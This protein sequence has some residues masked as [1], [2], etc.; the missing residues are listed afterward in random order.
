VR[1]LMI[2]MDVI[3][4]AAVGSLAGTA[5]IGRPTVAQLLVTAIVEGAATA[6]FAPA[7][8]ILLREIVPRER[9]VGGLSWLQAT[10]GI[11]SMAGP[12]LGGT[13][14]FLHPVAPF[15]ADAVSYGLSAILMSTIT[16]PPL[17]R[18]HPDRADARVTAG[19]RWLCHQPRIIRVVLY[20]SVL[21]LAGSGAEILVLLGLRQ[22]G[23]SSIIV[24][25]VLACA[26]VGAIVGAMLAGRMLRWLRGNSLYLVVGLSWAAGSVSF[27]IV[28]PVWFVAPMLVVLMLFAPAAGIRLGD[29][30]VNQA[31]RHLLGRVSTAQGMLA[32]GL[33]S[34]GPALV[35]VLLDVLGVAGSW[36]ILA[37]ICLGGTAIAV[38]SAAPTEGARGAPAASGAQEAA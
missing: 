32:S 1:A 15:A 28:R 35:G 17:V 20:A 23:T 2:G 27:A 37:V 33:A 4:L 10:T 29:L 16:V 6:A 14:F 5:G 36:V 34:V 12:L 19:L 26:G 22:E 25:M 21:N 13:L 11:V 18:R 8:T 31:P 7:A 9:L 3:R 38:G 24:G 30:T